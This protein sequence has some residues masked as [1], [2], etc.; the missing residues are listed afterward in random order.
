MLITEPKS[1][2]LK[3]CSMWIKSANVDKIKF[4]VPDLQ[5]KIY[6]AGAFDIE[7]KD[8]WQKIECPVKRISR[9]GVYIRLRIFKNY[10]VL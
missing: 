10:L 6:Y 8:E 3:T 9:L 5:T 7:K 4:L 1:T 2:D